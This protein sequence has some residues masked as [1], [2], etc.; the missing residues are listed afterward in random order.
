MIIKGKYSDAV[1]YGKAIDAKSESI[2]LNYLNHPD[3]ADTK[4]CIM[5]DVCP[6]KTTV[7][8][9]ASTYTHKIIPGILGYDIGCG[10]SVLNIGKGKLPFDKLDKYIRENIPYGNNMHTERIDPSKKNVPFF[11][12]LSTFW[13]GKVWKIVEK[14]KGDFEYIKNS[15]STL[16]GGNHFI[17]LDTDPEGNRYILVHTGS[18]GLGAMAAE[19]FSKKAINSTP[20]DS[21][22]KYLKDDDMEEYLHDMEIVQTFATD[23]MW[24]IVCRLAIDVFGVDYDEMIANKSEEDEE[25]V[26]D[27]TKRSKIITCPH[28]F[29]DFDNKIIRKGAVRAEVGDNI[30]I[31]FSMSEGSIL[32]TGKGNRDWLCSAP[33]GSGRKRA[34]GEAKG[35]SLDE[36]RKEMKG[37]WSSVV[38]KNTLDESPMAYKKPKDI[39]EYIDGATIDVITRLK[40][41]Y[42]FKSPN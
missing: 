38:G 26:A 15:F 5:P 18:R 21:P 36:Y 19:Y 8:G 17:E 11:G 10:V 42:N 16:G 29:I 35:L 27:E 25:G 6:A 30:I 40:P 37:V 23:N 34:R 7:V 1:F 12:M 13:D 41:V 33:H 4:V 28:N 32:G 20:K 31:P 2:V 39:L 24:S 22:I 14:Y 9:W 3:F